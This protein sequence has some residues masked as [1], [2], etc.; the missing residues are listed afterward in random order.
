MIPMGRSARSWPSVSHAERPME[1]CPTPNAEPATDLFGGAVSIKAISLWQPWASL[2]AAHV[3]RHETRHWPT[4]YRGPIAIHAAKRLDVAGAPEEL[5]IAALAPDWRHTVPLGAIVAVGTLSR[6][7][8]A[9]AVRCGLT[10]ADLAAGNYAP[11]RYAWTIDNVRAL[12]T[13]IPAI[14]RQGLFNWEPPADLDDRLG[15]PVGHEAACRYIG[16]A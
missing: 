15:A 16:W 7:R 4:A 9:R 13:P 10:Q 2:I 5:C 1:P 14:G 8:D 3:K 6:C 11:G 12:A